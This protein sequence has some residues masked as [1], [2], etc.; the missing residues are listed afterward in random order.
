MAAAKLQQFTHDALLAWRRE[1]GARG[2]RIQLMDIRRRQ[3]DE[4]VCVIVEVW[5]ENLRRERLT[6]RKYCMWAR[7]ISLQHGVGRAICQ[8]HAK[9]RNK[10]H[11]LMSLVASRC[12]HPKFHLPSRMVVHAWHEHA[13]RMQ[14]NVRLFIKK[15]LLTLKRNFLRDWYVLVQQGL[16]ARYRVRAIELHKAV[17]MAAQEHLE[18]RNANHRKDMEIDGLEQK[19]IDLE[20]AKRVQGVF[21]HELVHSLEE[22]RD[23]EARQMRDAIQKANVQ[24][25]RARAEVVHIARHRHARVSR[26]P[27]R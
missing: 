10:Y 25:L 19:L 22:E 3:L 23:Q 18:N 1:G 8:W 21:A 20:T 15:L 27:Q 11:Q 17:L 12:L 5:I 9:I 26:S 24:L 2:A 6:A 13:Y 16:K 14:Y 7:R 4:F